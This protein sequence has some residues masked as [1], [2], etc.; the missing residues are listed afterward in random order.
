MSQQNDKP[1]PIKDFRAGN[2]QASIWRNEVQQD[3]QTR[4]RHS[5]RIQKRYR[6]DDGNYKNTD[7]WFPDELP[8]L[9][10]LAQ[11]AFE[12]IVLTESKDAEDVPV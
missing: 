12:Y 3:G 9:Q 1:K 7:Y 4:I 2:I 5:I 10:L 11:K 6:K 8:R